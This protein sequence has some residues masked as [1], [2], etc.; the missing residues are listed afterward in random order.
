VSSLAS[1]P[2]R[3]GRSSRKAP[4]SAFTLVE[5]LVVIFIIG[6]LVMLVVGV[7][8]YVMNQANHQQT[9]TVQTIVRDAIDAF[10][11]ITGHYPPDDPNA[12]YSTDILVDYLSANPNDPNAPKDPN[13]VPYDTDILRRIESIVMPKL[14]N[15]PKE[16]LVNGVIYDGYDKA[17]RYYATGGMGGRPVLISDGTDGEPN[18]ED[19]IRSDEN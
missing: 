9:I 4:R 19:D 14:L 6:I 18:T 2:N 16:A 11:E 5:M 1:T 3:A 13:G 7:S 10:K 12:D 8:S 15:L 17:M